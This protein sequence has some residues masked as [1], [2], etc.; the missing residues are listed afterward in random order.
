MLRTVDVGEERLGKIRGGEDEGVEA[1]V[2]LGE[3]AEALLRRR[4]GFQCLGVE[5]HEPFGFVALRS[6]PGRVDDQRIAGPDPEAGDPLDDV[7]VDGVGDAL[8]L[9]DE[10]AA[11]D[12]LDESG[13]CRP[14][15]LG[16]D[17]QAVAHEEPGGRDR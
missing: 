9:P 13:P 15:L 6:R 5:A 1:L 12:A 11:F 17:V 2:G 3:C 10:V 7:A 16:D 4:P 14:D 8:G